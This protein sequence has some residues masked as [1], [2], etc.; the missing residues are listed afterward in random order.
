MSNYINLLPIVIV[1]VGAL[2]CLA[3]EPFI[4]DENKH[5]ILPW[6]ASLFVITGMGAYYLCS[7]D[8]IFNL[9]AMDPVRKVLG[10]SVMFCAFL[11]IAGLQWTLGH[12]KYKGGEAYALLMLATCGACLMTQAIDF[13]ALFIGMELASF[14]VYALV[15]IRRKDVN[16]N[17]GVFKYFVSGSVFSALFLY[18]VSLVYGATGTTHFFAACLP[19]REALY[20]IGVLLT[21]VGLLFKAGAAP[22]HFWVADVYTGASVAVTGFMAA[23][24]KIGA[25]AALASVWLGILVTKVGTAPAWNLAEPVTIASQSDGLFYLVVIVALLSMVIGAFSG[26]AQKSIRRI[27]AF[28]AVMNAGFIVIGLLL[29]NY[30]KSGSVQ[31]GAM[32][33][34][35][36]TYAVASAGA[37]TG[38]AYLAGREDR[39]ENLDDLQGCGRKRPYV[40]LGVTVCLASL[41]G[42]PPVAGFLAKFTLFTGAFSGGL[43]WLA[44]AGF[45]LSLV[46]AVYYLRIAF[47]LFMPVKHKCECQKSCCGSTPFAY[48]LRF[49][50]TVAAIALIVIGIFPNLA[51]I[52]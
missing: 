9:Y 27:L 51:L 33:Y 13:L 48:L 32:F 35:L 7:T 20:G 14:P 43:G 45:A 10:A 16:A 12:E 25:L 28:S 3:A 21:V 5:K 47:V 44:I 23:V 1:A 41:A 29:P 49:G 4:K 6:V 39:N 11:G 46:A 19:G 26:L 15:G 37:L 34:F 31:M 18:G 38:I 2:I 36:V 8:V 24:V 22:V 30:V 17:E 50:V 42:L 40:A 52:A